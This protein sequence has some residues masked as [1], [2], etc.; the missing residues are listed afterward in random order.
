M[1][2]SIRRIGVGGRVSPLFRPATA[3]QIIGAVGYRAAVLGDSPVGY[4][5]LEEPSGGFFADE[6]GNG[7]TGTVVSA[8]MGATGLIGGVL[9]SGSCFTFNGTSNRLT[10]P[11]S[12]AF[13]ASGNV[14]TI[15]CLVKGAGASSQQIV[16]ADDGNNPRFFQ[17]RGN[18]SHIELVLFNP[19]SGVIGTLTGSL[20]AFDSTTHHVAAVCDGATARL[21]VDGFADNTLP[22]TTIQNTN[23]G[24]EIGSR[25]G[26][27]S[28]YT[29]QID[30]IAYY[31][32]ALSAAAILRHAAL[33]G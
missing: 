22:Y 3:S 6:T 2:S 17:F 21:Y 25:A 30:E 20:T 19:A 14:F 32:T 26:G 18:S 33:R 28:F 29:G 4:W 12:A 23:R 24:F 16:S 15:E 10:I 7:H 31:T 11:S 5:R 8:T 13:N 9:G 27:S 1:R